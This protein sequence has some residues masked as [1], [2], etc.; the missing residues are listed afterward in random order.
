LKGTRWSP[1][2]GK[3]QRIAR[4][5]RSS[6]AQLYPAAIADS[7]DRDQSRDGFEQTPGGFQQLPK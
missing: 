7:P 5:G 2:P 4:A 6:A 3:L 1:Q